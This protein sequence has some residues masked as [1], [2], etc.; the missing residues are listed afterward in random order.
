M[1]K[2]YV[3]KGQIKLAELMKPRIYIG[4]GSGI[5]SGLLDRFLK[6]DK[7]HTS[8]YTLL[9][10]VRDW[11]FCDCIWPFSKATNPPAL[12]YGIKTNVVLDFETTEETH[13]PLPVSTTVD[14]SSQTEVVSEEATGI[15]TTGA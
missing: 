11:A 5:D 10:K 4:P 14:A 9:R 1:A 8:D 3:S 2:Y 7:I 15:K 6:R 12:P 13:A